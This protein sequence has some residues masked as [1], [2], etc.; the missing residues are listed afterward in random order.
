MINYS[1]I[2]ECGP[3]A[4]RQRMKGLP[5]RCWCSKGPGALSS[6]M[7]ELSPSKQ[8]HPVLLPLGCTWESPEELWRGGGGGKKAKPIESE[9]S[10]GKCDFFKAPRE[11]G[12]ATRIENPLR[13]LS[14]LSS[15]WHTLH[16][17][18]A[19]YSKNRSDRSYCP[20][21][22]LE[23]CTDAWFSQRS[24][25]LIWGVLWLWE[26]RFFFP[27]SFILKELVS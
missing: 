22:I 14:F 4:F 2:T 26:M 7:W 9:S 10:Q 27:Y 6:K 23:L 15:E 12:G 18:G 21:W 20:M 25:G 5:A 17:H 24:G 13:H 16:L 19:L 1:C 11:F 8:S 3:C